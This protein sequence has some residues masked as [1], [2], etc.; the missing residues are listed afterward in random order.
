MTRGGQGSSSSGSIDRR[1]NVHFRFGGLNQPKKGRVQRWEEAIQSNCRLSRNI[2]SL[3]V[4]L[5]ACA[6]G[7]VC[8]PRP[9]Q[10]ARL[11]NNFIACTHTH[12]HTYPTYS[13]TEIAPIG[14]VCENWQHFFYF[15]FIPPRTNEVV[16]CK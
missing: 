8:V 13:P 12:G 6:L 15:S 16:K 1:A 3:S 11:N 7:R 2:R 10:L 4:S 14:F 5:S 9:G